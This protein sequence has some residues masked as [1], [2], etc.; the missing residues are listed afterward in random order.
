MDVWSIAV[1]LCLA[2][3]A[4]EVTAVL[5]TGIS[6]RRG[7]LVLLLVAGALL[8][9]TVSEP[10][11]SNE[12]GG[13]WPELVA[14]VLLCTLTVF[15][16]RLL[17]RLIRVA[18]QSQRM[19]A[20]ARFAAVKELLQ[21]GRATTAEREL[22]ADF[23]SARAGG[24]DAVMR[25][26]RERLAETEPEDA[27][28]LHER[29]ITTLAFA[30]RWREAAA[31]FEAHPEAAEPLRHPALAIQMVQAYAATDQLE[32]AGQL[33]HRMEQGAGSGDPRAQAALQQLR[34]MFLAAVGG[35]Q[36]I[37]RLLGLPDLGRMPRRTRTLLAQ[38]AEAR[39]AAEPPSE[40]VV[41]FARSVAERMVAEARSAARDVA[42]R[43]VATTALIAVNVGVF[44][45][46]AILALRRLDGPGPRAVL[47]QILKGHSIPFLDGVDLV[48]IGASFHAA[49]RAGEWWR[50]WSAMFLHGGETL[51]QGLVHL[52]L[53]MYGLFLLGWFVEPMFGRGRFLV[54]YAVAGLVGNLASVVNPN[55]EAVLSLGAS[56]A[57]MGLLGALLVAFRARRGSGGEEWRRAVRINLYV[58]TAI[59]LG[60]GAVVH[61]VD[62]WAHVGGLLAGAATAWLLVPGGPIRGR[63][64][65]AAVALALVALGVSAA[66]SA[67]AAAREAPAATMAALPRRE[68]RAGGVR[69]TVPPQARPERPQEEEWPGEVVYVDPVAGLFSAPHLVALEGRSLDGALAACVERDRAAILRAAHESRSDPPAIDAAE[70]PS[71]DRWTARELDEGGPEAKRM[72]YYAR[73]LDARR[74]VVVEI[75]F[76]GRRPIPPAA[77]A[78]ID[79]VLASVEVDPGAEPPRAPTAK[80]PAPA[81]A[82]DGG[83]EVRR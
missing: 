41:R 45:L 26:L 78:E 3:V 77:R 13:P 5:R 42:P 33:V 62:N 64:G 22:L 17:D 66:W 6:A 55:P 40:E 11:F 43:P 65:K 50:L 30:G 79:R 12:G 61:V 35:A 54:I 29:M 19:V 15:I 46:T 63:L 80:A 38:V 14:G 27:E 28:P 57:V 56:G 76:D 16:P 4:L 59:Q 1:V 10:R 83:A 69:I 53:N 48:R 73:A 39:R 71:I 20:A 60:F 23:A 47:G 70:P 2:V 75:T 82:S 52:G 18:L 49:V 72:L 67:A 34:L 51:G 81:P 21:P 25:A 32:K 68:E 36:G 31:H 37:D 7:Y 58:L 8:G 24:V 74:A 44:L 9:Y